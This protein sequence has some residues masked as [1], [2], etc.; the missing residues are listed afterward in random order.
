M[1]PILS[2]R[3]SSTAPQ[4]ER[5]PQRKRKRPVTEAI[6]TGRFDD[7]VG[8]R[9]KLNFNPYWIWRQPF[10]REAVARPK[11]WLGVKVVLTT[12]KAQNR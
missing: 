8:L 10:S 11:V 2:Q 3:I 9:Q 7:L 5:C 4:D 1:D 12:L 6:V